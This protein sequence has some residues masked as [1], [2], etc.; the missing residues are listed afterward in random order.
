MGAEAHLTF[1]HGKV[2]HAA[3]ELEELLARVAVL[4]VLPDRVVHRLLGEAVFQLEGEYRQAVDEQDHV[5]GK[6]GLVAAIAELTADGE[7][8]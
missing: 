1:V 5:Q 4:L 8:V 7:A 6:L 2:G 3:A